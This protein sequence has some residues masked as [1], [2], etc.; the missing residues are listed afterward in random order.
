MKPQTSSE[1]QITSREWLTA[2]RQEG[3][4]EATLT[5]YEWHT[6]RLA[7]WLAGRGV[8]EPA[9]LSKTLLREWGASLHEDWSPAT[10]RQAVSAAKNFLT[11]CRDEEI[12]DEPL[13]NALRLP[14]NKKRA[15]YRTFTE[16]EISLLIARCDSTTAKGLRDIALI[17]LMIDSG[18]RA[19][20]VCRLRIGDI[21][22]GVKSGEGFTNVLVVKGKGGT[23]LPSYFGQDTADALYA[24]LDVRLARPGVEEV[25][26]SVGG[27]TPGSPLTREGLRAMLYKLCD[28]VGIKRGSPHALRRAF[29]CIAHDSG[30]SSRQIMEWGRWS[31][32]QMVERYT[33][34]YEAGR[35]Y[36]KHSPMDYI[37]GNKKPDA[38]Q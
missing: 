37:R 33:R 25:F 18:L 23:E 20:E 36:A 8:T 5:Q 15:V 32:I 34:A 17:H 24:W 29:A 35:R 19:S 21:Q 2:L 22:V 3:A 13:A 26:V 30:A 10:V 9:A 27:L 31:N 12:I 28:K 38:A 14:K 16:E 11:W 7:D 4:S 1:L 6:L